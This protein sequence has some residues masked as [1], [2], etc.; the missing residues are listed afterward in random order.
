MSRARTTDVPADRLGR[1]ALA[2]PAS[3]HHLAV[4]E[5]PHWAIDIA[6]YNVDAIP[7]AEAIAALETY[8]ATLRERAQGWEALE[9]CLRDVEAAHRIA[10][11]S[12]AEHG[13]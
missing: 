3:T 4:P 6:T 13:Q 1:R 12:R 5:Y 8:A 10:G 7:T 9:D 11:R 2:R